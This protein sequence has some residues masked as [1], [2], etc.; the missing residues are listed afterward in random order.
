MK[1]RKMFAP[2]LMLLAGAVTSIVM[3]L[4]DCGTTQLLLT[5]LCVLIVFY[6]IGS[7][8]Q[9]FVWKLIDQIE[10]QERIRIENEGEVIEKEA[11]ESEEEGTET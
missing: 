8:I 9:K 6:A 10:E 2:F 7:V 11:V 4:A 3:F 5:L 1:K